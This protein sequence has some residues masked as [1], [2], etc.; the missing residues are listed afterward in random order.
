MSKVT[1]LLKG[2]AFQFPGL[3]LRQS[4]T[5]FQMNSC[6]QKYRV[7]SEVSPEVFRMFLSVLKGT[8]IEV[9]NL[10]FPG[11]SALCSE[12]GF[13]LKSLS[14]RLSQVEAALEQPR[15]ASRVE[16]SVSPAHIVVPLTANRPSSSETEK[17]P[18]RPKPNERRVP[19]SGNASR[20]SVSNRRGSVGSK[21][22][23][24]ENLEAKL[25]GFRW[26]LEVRE[27][28]G[29]AR[30]AALEK[31]TEQV[32][33]DIKQ[34]RSKLISLDTGFKGLAGEGT[35]LGSAAKKAKKKSAKV[36]ELSKKVSTLKRQIPQRNSTNAKKTQKAA[37]P[38]VLNGP[39][40]SSPVA[41]QPSPQKLPVSSC[42]SL[43]S[44]II[45]DFP[46]IFADFYGKR[47]SLLWRGTSNGFAASEFHRR[48]DG[49]ANTLTLIL[50]TD[51]NSFGGFTPVKWESKQW[52]R[53]NTDDDNTRKE[54][55]SSKSFLFTL[56]NPHNISAKRFASSLILE[57]IR[58]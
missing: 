19:L 52:N 2:E 7:T 46:V 54:D 32:N 51:G 33:S 49:H 24:L 4:C 20:P 45:A 28:E 21:D 48:C 22:L 27:E 6:P 36:D 37:K 5:A 43:D 29:R 58:P 18:A 40:A 35:K 42:P 13:K 26:W 50:D 9:T 56:K 47:L 53:K 3:V 17:P 12:F 41:I 14:Y 11:L 8:E 10:N 30:I 1:L 39:V 23:F 57:G 55:Y 31:R 16:L 25:P 44:R 15:K 34:L 38:A